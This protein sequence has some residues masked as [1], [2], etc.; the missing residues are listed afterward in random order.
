MIYVTTSRA[1]NILPHTFNLSNESSNLSE[2]L[3]HFFT[4]QNIMWW[5]LVKKT[6]II[7]MRSDKYNAQMKNSS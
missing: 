3:I 5:E 6:Q 1:Y 7:D 4:K 2:S